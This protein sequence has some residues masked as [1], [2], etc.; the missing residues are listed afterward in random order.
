MHRFQNISIFIFFSSYPFGGI[1]D[2]LPLLRFQFFFLPSSA[3]AQAQ[4]GA[5]I[6]LFSQLWGTS[7]HPTAYTRNRSFA[8]LELLLSQLWGLVHVHYSLATYLFIT[9]ALLVHYLFITYSQLVHTL[10]VT[11][12]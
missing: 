3:Q 8:C 2:T 12:S 1:L 9:C 11:C 4:L 5:E 7:I 10:F 6:A